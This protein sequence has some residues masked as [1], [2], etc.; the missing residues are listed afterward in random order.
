M[1][2]KVSDQLLDVGKLIDLKWKV[3][4]AVSSDSCKNLNSPFVCLSLTISDGSGNIKMH[5]LELSMAQF[6]VSILN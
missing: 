2:F 1:N 3:G 5:D 6:R 4:M